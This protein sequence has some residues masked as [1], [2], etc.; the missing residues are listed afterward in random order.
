MTKTE[1]S[2][3]EKLSQVAH[4]HIIWLL[5]G[6]YAVASILPA[7][8][9][10]LKNLS[11]G[12]ITL[13]H[14]T[15]T[16]SVPVLMLAVLLFNAGL[17]VETP[18]LCQLQRTPIVLAFGLIANLLMPMIFIFAVSRTA[19][20]WADAEQFQD[21]LVGLGLV[22]CMPIAGSSTAWSQNSGGDVAVSMGLVLLSTFVSPMTTPIALHSVGMM[23]SG[24]QSRELH[25]LA[26]SGT[27]G[28]LIVS[29][30]IPSLMGIG[31]RMVLG[32]RRIAA[33]K[34]WV[35][36]ANCL[37]LLV[38]NYSNTSAALPQLLA[39]PEWNFMIMIL[40]IVGTLCV[41][42]FGSGWWLADMLQVDM[43]QRRS[44]MFGLGMNNNG[45]GLV[46]GSLALHHRPW[47][48][49]PIIFYNLAQHIIAGIAASFSAKAEPRA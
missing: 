17:E 39:H 47:I 15:T 4:N 35:S 5:I 26:T 38:L 16:L 20:L 46:L 34:H 29:I 36:L 41:L 12:Q 7:P 33:V 18:H 45:T 23:A 48:V 2:A 13:L 11:C 44:L 42:A 9:L 3:I 24:E 28:F 21:L 10:W 22:A 6:S 40:A 27:S 14:Q 43:R 19:R 25:E 8:G 49:A 1:S 37:V 31:S 32:Q 30:I